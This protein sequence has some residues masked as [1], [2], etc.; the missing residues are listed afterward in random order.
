M[1]S[2][3]DFRTMQRGSAGKPADPLTSCDGFF[4][5]SHPYMTDALALRRLLINRVLKSILL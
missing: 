1:P 4:K 2:K 5:R 3:R